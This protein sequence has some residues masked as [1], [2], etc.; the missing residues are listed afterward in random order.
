MDN[1]LENNV[2]VEEKP[3]K[4][5]SLLVFKIVGTAL[6]S[7]VTIPFVV[8]I[9]SMLVDLSKEE[10]GLGLG[11][12]KAVAIILFAIGSAICL[13]VYITP[14]VFGIIGLLRTVKKLEKGKRAGNM[15]WFISMIALPVISLALEIGS[16]FLVKYI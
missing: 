6:Y 7:V 12:G 13:I 4:L 1:N 15:A 8:F 5:K 11:I 9:I 16:I 14:V 2:L 3:K 10:D